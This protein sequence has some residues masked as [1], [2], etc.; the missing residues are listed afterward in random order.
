MKF[1][2]I[3]AK[4]FLM[5]PCKN[6]IYDYRTMNYSSQSYDPPSNLPDRNPYSNRSVLS[7]DHFE[8]NIR[9]QAIFNVRANH[10]Y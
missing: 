1:D 4:I 7:G 8:K 5:N 3:C 10:K 9:T 2:P 6:G